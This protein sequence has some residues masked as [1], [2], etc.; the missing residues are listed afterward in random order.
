MRV[1]SIDG[2]TK[3]HAAHGYCHSHY[4][5]WLNNGTPV[6]LCQCGN[7]VEKRGPDTHCSKCSVCSVNKCTK[8]L[9]AHGYCEP[10]YRNWLHV[11]MPIR[12]CQICGG[13]ATGSGSGTYCS[14]CRVCSINGCMRE[15]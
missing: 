15:P 4:V 10:H 6:R 2:C 7:P 13:D 3:Q 14:K 12:L 8:T 5:N 1:C 9:F 11:G